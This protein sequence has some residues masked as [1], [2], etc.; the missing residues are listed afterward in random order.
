ME[1]A[2][3]LRQLGKIVRRLLLDSKSVRL[4]NW[5]TLSVTL[6]SEGSNTKEELTAR[7]I[8]TVNTNFQP[9]EDLHAAL[10]KAD[11]VWINKIMDGKPGSDSGTTEPGNPDA[12]GDGGGGEA[13][14]PIG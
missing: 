10:Q 8:K 1:A 5:A 4:G 11:F 9:S 2:M 13:P 12:G 3:A 14:D 7:N 6:S